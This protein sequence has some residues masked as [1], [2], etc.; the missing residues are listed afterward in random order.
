MCSFNCRPSLAPRSI[1]GLLVTGPRQY[2]AHNCTHDVHGAGGEAQW[3]ACRCEYEIQS[4]ERDPEA[5]SHRQFCHVIAH[6]DF[7]LFA[8]RESSQLVLKTDCDIFVEPAAHL[9]YCPEIE[10][11]KGISDARP[12]PPGRLVGVCT[13]PGC[14]N[15]TRETAPAGIVQT[16]TVAKDGSKVQ[17]TMRAEGLLG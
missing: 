12:P 14:K 15:Q 9:L 5:A 3:G 10:G 13:G 4:K 6:T 1:L 11:P 2:Y 7:L 17:E 16:T 8:D